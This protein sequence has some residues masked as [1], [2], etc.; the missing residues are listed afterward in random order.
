MTYRILFIHSKK[1]IDTKI[2]QDKYYLSLFKKEL[3]LV[4]RFIY[5]FYII[6]K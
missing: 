2:Y 4:F 6:I 5:I 3:N 1:D